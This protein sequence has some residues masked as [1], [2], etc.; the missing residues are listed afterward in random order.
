MVRR[1]TAKRLFLFAVLLVATLAAMHFTVPER[2]RSVSLEYRFRDTL[3]PV[4]FGLTW[5]SG[6]VRH[7]MSFPVSMVKAGA[8]NQ[9]LEQEVARLESQVV[10]LTEYKLESERLANLLNYKQ[11]IPKDYDLLA[12]SVVGRDPGN[13]FG[14]VCLN[15]GAVD[16]VKENMT[17]VTP[18]GLVGRVI[19]VS[20]AT[21]EV[22]LIT[23]PRSGVGS[24]IQETRISGVVEGIAG[25]IGMARMIH[26]PNNAPLENGQAVITSGLGSIFPK[27]IP[28]GQITDIR[29]E[30][31]GLFNS[32][33]LR[34]YADLNRLEEVLI[35]ITS[36]T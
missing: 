25:S 3:A 30:P 7:L 26:I 2:T 35:I 1:A 21:C 6:Q 23:D 13:W 8:R 11:V 15:R 4:K 27:D 29:R 19:S 31:S 34:P 36:N 5:L 22:L 17:V 28:I 10:Q 33:D 18:E 14:T 32:A 20:S 9:F 16:G 12:A 24:L